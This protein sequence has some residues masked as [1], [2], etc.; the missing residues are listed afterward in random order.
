[1]NE[2]LVIVKVKETMKIVKNVVVPYIEAK[3]EKM[4]IFMLLRLLM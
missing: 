2:T 3:G 4:E 1:V